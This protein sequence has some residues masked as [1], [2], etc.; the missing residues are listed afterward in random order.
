MYDQPV[1]IEPDRTKQ[2][3]F[4]SFEDIKLGTKIRQQEQISIEDHSLEIV[5]SAEISLIEP[6][7][8]QKYTKP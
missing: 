6:R 3:M 2:P 8:L 1:S 5:P 7:Q 4:E